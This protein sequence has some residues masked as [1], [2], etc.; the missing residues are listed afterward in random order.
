MI[1]T[2][3]FRGAKEDMEPVLVG[4]AVVKMKL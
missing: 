3:N 2:Q 4:E 1:G